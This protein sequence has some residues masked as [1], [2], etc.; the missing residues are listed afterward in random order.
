MLI[1]LTVQFFPFA[2]VTSFLL[3]ASIMFSLDVCGRQA[4]LSYDLCKSQSPAQLITLCPVICIHEQWWCLF[5]NCSL[6]IV[7]TSISFLP[8]CRAWSLTRGLWQ[9]SCALGTLQMLDVKWQEHY[10]SCIQP[11]GRF[12]NGCW[13]L[14][15]SWA[16]LCQLLWRFCCVCVLFRE[17]VAAVSRKQW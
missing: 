17:L 7:I 13:I 4:C 11:F 9:V 15:K 2:N 16:A 10:F 5:L 14:K 3:L 1:K 6:T 8:L 12:G